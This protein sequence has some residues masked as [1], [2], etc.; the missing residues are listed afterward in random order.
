MIANVTNA[1]GTSDRLKFSVDVFAVYFFDFHVCGAKSRLKN[2]RCS[3]NTSE[4][5]VICLTIQIFFVSCVGGSA[6]PSRLEPCRRYNIFQRA[7]AILGVMLCIVDVEQ[8]GISR[9]RVCES[10]C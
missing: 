3:N 4:G 5:H 10:T 2:D 8:N 7:F 1:F 6:K 9:I